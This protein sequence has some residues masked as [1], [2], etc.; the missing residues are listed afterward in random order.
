M[1]FDVSDCPA[2]VSKIARVVAHFV[3]RAAWIGIFVV[4][5]MSTAIPILLAQDRVGPLSPATLVEI[6]RVVGEIDH[7]ELRRD[8][9]ARRAFEAVVDLVLQELGGLIQEIDGDQAVRQPPDHL[10]AA[11][12]DRRQLAEFVEHRE[13]FLRLAEGEERD[14]DARTACRHRA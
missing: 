6:D 8:L 4:A 13:D 2:G 7:G 9:G 10:V 14:E 5:M 12:A 3:R 11:A 1:D